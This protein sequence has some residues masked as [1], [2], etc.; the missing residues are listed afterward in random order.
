MG[1]MGAMA[2]AGTVRGQLT[3]ASERGEKGP[4]GLWRLDNGLLA[5]QARPL[6]PRS[7]CVVVLFPKTPGK[8]KEPAK[9][10]AVTAELKGL[11][12]TPQV[13]VV[14]L[15][16]ALSIKNEDRVPYALHATGSDEA[17]YPAR[18]LPA[19]GKREEVLQH[20]GVY[21]LRDDE[22]AHLRGWVIVTEGA[23]ALRPDEHWAFRGEVPDGHYDL[24][25]FYRG[26]YVV[27]KS[28]DVSS[29]SLELQLT[30]P[31]KHARSEGR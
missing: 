3:V 14:P 22:Q 30:I 29:K 26:G 2:S 5:V 10:E 19:G 15:G 6:D 7:E 13:I 23:V 20:P 18:P 8:G 1:W 16:A 24:K 25:V 27:E 9:G 11:R 12:L 4:E 31:A 21:N 28:V 17:A